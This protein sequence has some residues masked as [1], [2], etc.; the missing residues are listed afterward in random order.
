MKHCI[1]LCV[2]TFIFV[3]NAFAN[4]TI[5]PLKLE[6]KES[7]KVISAMLTNESDEEKHF[8][9]SIVK[10]GKKGDK[11]NSIQSKDLMVTPLM[12]KIQ[13][14]KQQLIRI[15]RKD[16][17]SNLSDVYKL[18]V[19]ELP[20]KQKGDNVVHLVTQFNIPIS[21][22]GGQKNKENSF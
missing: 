9:V 15:A 13:P 1:R 6:F 12:F 14:H 4:F 2:L 16:L 3:S 11:V 22:G 7:E 20:H 18:E 10:L 21:L 19:K 17:A 8:Q 5:S